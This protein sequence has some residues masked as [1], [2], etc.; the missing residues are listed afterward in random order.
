MSITG[1][2]RTDLLL[3]RKVLSRGSQNLRPPVRHL[4]HFRAY[5]GQMNQ[6]DAV[7]DFHTATAHMPLL[8]KRLEDFRGSEQLNRQ[9]SGNRRD[10]G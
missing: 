4:A 5:G 10:G 9:F 8:L 3:C 6:D 7:V 1:A 2:V